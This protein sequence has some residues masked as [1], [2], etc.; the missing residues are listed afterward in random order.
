VDFSYEVSRSLK[1]CEGAI[2]LVDAAQGVQAQTVANFY[3]ALENDLEIIPVINKIDLPNADPEKCLRQIYDLTGLKADEVLMVSAKKGTGIEELLELVV[4]KVPP[5]RGRADHPLQA[6]IFNSVYDPYRGVIVHIR[7]FEGE[8]KTGDKIRLFHSGQEFDVAELGIFRPE[9]EAVKELTAGGAG[10]VIATIK[11]PTSVRIGDT[12]TSARIPCEEPLPGFKELRPVVFSGLYPINTADYEELKTALTKLHLNDPSFVYLPENS[13]ALGFGFR[14][15]FLGLLHL[16]II[17]ERLQREYDLDLIMTSPSVVYQVALTDGKEISLD[18]PVNLPDRTRIRE[19]REPFI[20]AYI[21]TPNEHIGQIMRINQ[22]KRGTCVATETLGKKS[23]ILTMEL[24]LN[25]VVLD[26]YDLIK[27]VTHGY[28]S[29]DYDQ[30]GY[31]PSSL[32]KLEILLNGEVV[33]AFSCLVHRDKAAGRGR[34]LAEKL[35]DV[36]PRQQFRV[37]IQASADGNIIARETVKPYR[38]DVIAHLY[39]G[40]RTRKDKLL[41]KQKKGK[42]RMK[43]V[44]QVRVPQ[45]AFLEVMKID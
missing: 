15:G 41:K 2:L 43:M 30:L 18:N 20:R 13:A 27:S 25:E 42:K 35:K 12:L 33:D 22:E 3:L 21:I 19:I 31:R 34:K 37:A 1:A 36:I 29:L 11:D 39:G 16:E 28:G 10:Y 9:M 44:G 40:D 32:V 38:K 7:V 45:K 14:R 5:P 6:L 17:Q 8:L 24:P 23:V 4:E 26:F